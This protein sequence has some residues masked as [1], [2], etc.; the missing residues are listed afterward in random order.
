MGITSYFHE[1]LSWGSVLG[2]CSQFIV[3]GVQKSNERKS[4]S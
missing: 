3:K 2:R 4:A 1:R